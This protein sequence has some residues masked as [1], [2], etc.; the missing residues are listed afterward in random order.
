MDTKRDTNTAQVRASG[1]QVRSSKHDSRYHECV[2]SPWG[3]ARLGL[4]N[5]G[6]GVRVPPRVF[7]NAVFDSKRDVGCNRE[8]QIRQVS[9]RGGPCSRAD[10]MPTVNTGPSQFGLLRPATSS[11]SCGTVEGS[12]ELWHNSGPGFEDFTNP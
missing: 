5:R 12:G 11:F 9:E 3:L 7:R 8:P 1:V 2:F 4:R 6:L 10:V